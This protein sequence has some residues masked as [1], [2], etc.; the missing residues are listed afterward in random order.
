MIDG[1]VAVITGG[2]SGIGAAAVRRFVQEG[3]RVVFGDLQ[4][5]KGAALAAELGAGACRFLRTDVTQSEDVR[6]LV[7]AAVEAFGKLDAI[8]NNAGIGGGEGPI[9]DCAEEQFDRIIAVDLKAVWLGMKHAL[10]YLIQNGG[11]AIVSTASVSGLMGMPG[12]GA[13]GAAKGGVIQLTRVCA[14]EN[15]RHFVRVNCVCP[16]GTLTPILYAN[17]FRARELDPEEVRAQLAHAQPIPRAGLPED[18]AAAALWL[19]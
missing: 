7:H 8:Y 1:K 15:A 9:T 2:A 12:Q 18:I 13:Y 11:G 14:V 6:A 16:G 19:V 10:P 5:E 3:A 17:P 4:E